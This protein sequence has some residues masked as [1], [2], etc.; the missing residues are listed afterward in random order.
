MTS[1]GIVVKVL[2]DDGHLKGPI[3]LQIFTVVVIAE[4]ITLLLIGFSIGE[5]VQRVDPG[6][7]ILILLGKVA[8]VRH[9]VMDTLVPRVLPP[10]VVPAPTGGSRCPQLSL[11]LLLGFLFLIVWGAEVMG[12]PRLV[13]RAAVRRLPVGAAVPGSAGNYAWSA[14]RG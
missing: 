11:G 13:G 10:V 5:H 12:S 1:L 14:Q 3:G 9:C 8:G 4:L 6:T 7:G 2:A